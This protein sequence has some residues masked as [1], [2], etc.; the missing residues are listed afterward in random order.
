MK[1]DSRGLAVSTESEGAIHAIDHYA[2]ELLSLGTNAAAVQ[3]AADA[4]PGCAMLQACCASTFLYSQT[5]AGARKSA[6]HLARAESAPSWQKSSHYTV[7]HN[8][9]HLATLYLSELRFDDVRSAYRKYVWGYS[10]DAVVEQTDAILLLWYLERRW[11]E[12]I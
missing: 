9:F 11:A 10:P 6:P 12:S 1:I 3:A 4:N 8:W 2:H 5:T 7:A